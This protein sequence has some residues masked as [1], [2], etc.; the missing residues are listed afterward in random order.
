MRSGV[1]DILK[2]VGAKVEVEEVR[3]VKTRRQEQGSFCGGE[4][5]IEKGEKESD[6]KERGIEEGK[7]TD[8]R[9]FNMERETSEVEN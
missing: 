9:R 1:Q 6:E 7:S 5:Q 8:R 3:K 4:F 2:I